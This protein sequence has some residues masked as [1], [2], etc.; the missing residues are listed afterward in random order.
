[1]RDTYPPQ[2]DRYRYALVCP[3]SAPE[4]VVVVIPCPTAGH[5]YLL[6]GAGYG[7]LLFPEGANG[8]AWKI[9]LAQSEAAAHLAWLESHGYR[10]RQALMKFT[11]K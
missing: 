4:S 3:G 11:S 5:G 1:M 7:S 10:L 6:A 8:A 2:T 9:T